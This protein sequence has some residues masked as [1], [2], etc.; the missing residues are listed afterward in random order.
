MVNTRRESE[1]ADGSISTARVVQWKNV[2]GTTAS[3]ERHEQHGYEADCKICDE[4]EGNNEEQSTTSCFTRC[5]CRRR[6]Q[7]KHDICER[8]KE[9]QVNIGESIAQQEMEQQQLCEKLCETEA[10][11][12]HMRQHYFPEDKQL[13]H[14]SK[15]LKRNIIKSRKLGNSDSSGRSKAVAIKNDQEAAA[16]YA[17]QMNDLIP[18]LNFSE[19][20]TVERLSR[21]GE[22]EGCRLNT[23]AKD[24]LSNNHTVH[25]DIIDALENPK[26]FF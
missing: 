23:I 3:Y 13:K 10:V 22:I 20:K 12:Q 25:A 15:S 17:V 26:Q 1:N 11:I 9:Q 2:G 21:L 16:R 14:L 5:L 7:R 24:K 19:A 6:S 4:L 18:K 8:H